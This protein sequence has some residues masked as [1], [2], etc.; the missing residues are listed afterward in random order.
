MDGAELFSNLFTMALFGF[1]LYVTILLIKYLIKV[2]EY[3][4]REAEA[5][6]RTAAALEWIAGAISRKEQRELAEANRN[7]PQT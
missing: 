5:Q 1:Y 7:R 4:R 2:P 6:E 3:H